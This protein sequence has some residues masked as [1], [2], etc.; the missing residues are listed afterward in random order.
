[1]IGAAHTAGLGNLC[2]AAGRPFAVVTPL[3]LKTNDKRGDIDKQYER[4]DNRL[5]VQP[6]GLFMTTV[7]R[8]TTSKKPEP[9]IT[10]VPWFE[11]KARI[12]QFTD[13]IVNRI[14]VP[15]SLPGGGKPPYS[16]ADAD[17]RT[18]LVQIDPRLIAYNSNDHGQRTVMFPVTINP[19]HKQRPTTLWVKAAVG[20]TQAENVADIE[21][22]LQTALAEVQR[23]TGTPS[24]AENSRDE[25]QMSTNTVA[26]VGVDR[27]AVAQHALSIA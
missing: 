9:V 24:Q 2:E 17:L 23:E 11:A 15:S 8:A 4:K 12:Y 10:P 1:V 20:T 26:F 16:F 21:R 14:L 27:K 19:G 25:I 22:L 18:P 13:E 6:D 7:A 5:S 3:A